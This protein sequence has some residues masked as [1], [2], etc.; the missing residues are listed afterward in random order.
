[1]LKVIR[2]LAGS[3]PGVHRKMI[4]KLAGSSLEVAMKIAGRKAACL[5]RPV[6][7]RRLGAAAGGRFHDDATSRH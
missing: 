1:S 2:K 3:T 5:R 4:E 7:W 6:R